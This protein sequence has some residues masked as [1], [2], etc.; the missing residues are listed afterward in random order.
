MANRTLS[1]L[2]Y[3][4]IAS[5]CACQMLN[6]QI[7]FVEL[8]NEKKTIRFLTYTVDTMGCEAAGRTRS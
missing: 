5:Q 8:V 7:E 1:Q 6:V 4:T 2:H 3:I